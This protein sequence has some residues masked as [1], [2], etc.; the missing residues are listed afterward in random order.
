[1]KRLREKLHSQNGA[2]ILMALLMFLLCCMVAA[3]VLA[4]A[5][6]NAGKVRS[7]RVEQQRYLLLSSAIRLICDELEEAEYTAKYKVW[8]WSVTTVEKPTE[9]AEG[10][11]V[12]EK[13]SVEHFFY[14]EQVQGDY[15]CG[16]KRGMPEGELT[17]QLPLLY[18][19][20]AI[21]NGQFKSGDGYKT[22]YGVEDGLVLASVSTPH[23]LTVTVDFLPDTAEQSGPDAYKMSNTVK[24]KVV[25]APSTRHITLT[26]WESTGMETEPPSGSET[27]IAELAAVNPP[28]LN[29]SPSGRTGVEKKD[30]PPADSTTKIENTETKTETTT[31]I[32]FAKPGAEKGTV[33]EI[34]PP[35]T[36]E[37]NWIRKGAA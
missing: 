5:V 36:W 35:M 32:A 13:T 27:M 8:E 23:I 3:S 33:F 14:C 17:D 30:M 19:L 29:Y 11:D 22:G 20:D 26:A 37:L 21:F 25:L 28:V 7:N 34:T 18:E 24:V 2:S 9:P 10:E 31:I 6:S 4:A 16:V 12:Q 15:S 1:M